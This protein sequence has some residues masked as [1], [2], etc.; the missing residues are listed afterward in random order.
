MLLAQI[1]FSFFALFAL[2]RTVVR[3]RKKEIPLSWFL[4]WIVFWVIVVIAVILPWTTTLLADWIGIGRGV[5]LVIYFS[6]I[7]L[8]YLI[9]RLFVKIEQIERNITKIVEKNAIRE[10]EEKNSGSDSEL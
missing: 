3:Y 8:F 4:F 6:I 5:D 2:S 10:F 7:I 1:I 9:F